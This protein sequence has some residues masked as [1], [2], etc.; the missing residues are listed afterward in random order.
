M[1][2]RAIKGLRKKWNLNW[3]RLGWVGFGYVQKGT[4]DVEN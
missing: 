3:L 1:K 4:L 2:P